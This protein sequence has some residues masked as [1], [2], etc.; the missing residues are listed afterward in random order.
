MLVMQLVEQGKLDLDEPMSHYA[1]A[2][3]DDSV[4]VRHIITH[5]SAGIPGERFRYSG[6]LYGHLTAVLEKKT[7]KKFS[8]LVVETFFEPLGMTSSVPYH[9]VVVDADKWTATLGKDKLDRYKKN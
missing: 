4:K 2:F 9:N 6:N 5:T 7:G 3:K 8:E 1:T